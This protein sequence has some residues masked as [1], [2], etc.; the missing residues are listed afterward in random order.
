MTNRWLAGLLLAVSAC[1]PADRTSPSEFAVDAGDQTDDDGSGVA[2]VTGTVWAPGNAPGFVPAG[3]EIPV[4][5]AMVYLGLIKPDPIPQRVECLAC[6]EAPPSAQITDA[7]GNFTLHP[8]PGTYWLVV[9]KAQFRLEQEVVITGTQE[10]GPELTTLPSVHD[11]DNGKWIPHIALA[12]G[13]YDAME[14][15]LGKMGIGQVGPD[16]TFI[17]PS[18]IG[19]FDVYSNGGWDLDSVAVG[20][21]TQLVSDLD[22]MMNYHII[23]IPCAGD[24]N[25]PALRDQGNLRN[26]RDYV[27]AGGRLYVT[28]WSGEWMDNVFPEAIELKGRVDTPA[29]A[30]NRD[31]DRWVLTEFGNADGSPSYSSPDA[32][33][34]DPDLASWLDGQT[35]PTGWPI[36]PT[37]FFVEG[38]WDHIIGLHD[39]EIGVDDEGQPVVDKPRPYVVGSDGTAGGKKTLTATFEPTGCGRVLYSTYHT[40]ESVHVGL[41]PQERVLLYLLLEIGVCKDDPVVE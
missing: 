25:H 14:S 19:R 35:G 5:G 23:F 1:G 36:D 21:L 31:T 27:K 26:I 40:T 18:A 28:D 30:Y 13:D 32:E 39:V 22:R 38:N 12:A 10:L 9:Q 7:K 2:T 34:V 8:A 20:S 6:V 17:P 41:E 11:P 24:E 29:N 15:I 16:G 33:A 3:H 37:A 4:A